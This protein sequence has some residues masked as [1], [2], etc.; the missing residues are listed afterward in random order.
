MVEEEVITEVDLGEAEAEDTQI[1]LEQM[2][3]SQKKVPQA[4]LMKS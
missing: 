2:W 3:Q 4:Q 1:V